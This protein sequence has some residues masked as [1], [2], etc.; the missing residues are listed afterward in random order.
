MT[1]TS[2]K[3]GTKQ[4][5]K[6]E[7]A[8][9]SR[10]GQ[11]LTVYP[12]EKLRERTQFSVVVEYEGVVQPIVDPDDSIEGFIPTDDGAY[13]VNEPQA[14]PARTRPTT[15]RRTRRSSTCRSWSPRG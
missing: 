14:R 2:I 1:V 15:T 9:W 12:R 11:E 3:T 5:F 7:A 13:V 4:G 8:E 6:M 10:S